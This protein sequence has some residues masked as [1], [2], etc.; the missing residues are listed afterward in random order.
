MGLGNLFVR[1]AVREVGRNLGKG[2]SN[3]LYGDWHSTPVRMAKSSAQRNGVNLDLIKPHE[4]DVTDQPEWKPN[5]GYF[6]SFFWN[7][8]IACIPIVNF[9]LPFFSIKDFFRTETPM[10]AKVPARRQ[11]LRYNIGYRDLGYTWVM[12]KSKRRL[13]SKEK[14]NSRIAGTLEILGILIGFMI[15][16]WLYQGDIFNFCYHTGMIN[17]LFDHSATINQFCN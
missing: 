1:A 10:Y 14:T 11:D 16:N 3:E 17:V 7:A 4:Y 5:W 2:I 9:I 15:I 8:L 13:T 12:L 6:G